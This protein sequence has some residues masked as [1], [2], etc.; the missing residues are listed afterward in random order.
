MITNEFKYSFHGSSGLFGISSNLSSVKLLQKNV[1]RVSALTIDVT[2]SEP[3]VF[4][5][6]GILLLVFVLVFTY[7][8]N[9]FGDVL[10]FCARLRSNSSF[11]FLVNDL[12]SFLT[13]LNRIRS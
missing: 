9:D 12:S 4:L 1:L 13:L 11:N 5:S 3:S 10:M 7:A 2:V 8:Q 6:G